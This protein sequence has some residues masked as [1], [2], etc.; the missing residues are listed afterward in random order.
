MRC[1]LIILLFY[2]SNIQAQ[3]Y[4]P[5]QQLNNLTFR[6]IDNTNGL[7]SNNVLSITQDKQGFIWVGSHKGLQRYDGSG[8][9]KYADKSAYSLYTNSRNNNIYFYSE[10]TYNRISLLEPAIT[11]EADNYAP[12]NYFTD[13]HGIRWQVS[14]NVPPGAN[15]NDLPK[16]ISCRVGKA[17][18]NNNHL[19][20]MVAE[21]GG[22]RVWILNNQY[23]L[24]L[25]DYTTHKMYSAGYN[26]LRH[27]LLAVPDK[28]SPASGIIADRRGN[29]W[30]CT[31]SD[32]F[33]RYHMPTGTFSS[34]STQKIHAQSRESQSWVNTVFTDNHG[35]VW[36]ATANAGLLQYNPEKDN[37]NYIL[38]EQKNS[39]SIQYNYEIF[40]LFQDR[41]ENIWVGSDKGISVFNPYRRYFTILRHEEDNRYS[42][43]KSEITG[44]IETKNGDLLIAT[45]GAG[46]SVY[47]SLHRFKRVLRFSYPAYQVNLVWSFVEQ[48]DGTI[49]AGCQHGFLLIINPD[50]WAVQYIRPPQMENATIR[51]MLKDR[52]G[53]V[54]FGLHNGKIAQWNKN[55]DAFYPYNDSAARIRGQTEV[56]NIFEDSAG[57]FWAMT[58]QGLK[59]FDPV[60]RAFMASFYP[61]KK[62]APVK[63]A[64]NCCGIEQFNDSLLLVGIEN[65]GLH[66]FNKRTKHF[67]V[68][69]INEERLPY[70]AYAIKKDK[71]GNVW[72]TTDYDIYKYNTQTQTAVTC[73]PEKG[74][75]SA[76]FVL[77]RF[78]ITGKGQWFSCTYAEVIGFYPGRIS[79]QQTNPVPVTITGLKVFD[80]PVFI[81]SLLYAGKPI[82]LSYRQNFLN[83]EFASLLYAGIHQTKYYYQLSNVDKKWV[84]AG[85]KRFASYTNLGPGK[86]TFSVKAE[87]GS[88]TSKITTMEIEI[89]TPF[90]QT[91]WFIL[92]CTAVFIGMLYVFIR[93]RISSVR[94]AAHMKQKMS[95]TEM[96]AL[97]AQ[98]NPHFIFNCINSIDAMIQSNE[99]Y[100]ATVYLNKFAKLIRNIL[101]SSRHTTIPLGRDLETLQLYIDMEQFRNDNKFVAE[102]KADESLLQE[103]YRVPPLVIQPY[104]ENAILHGLRNRIDNK[105][106]LS[107]VVSKQANHLVYV[108]EDNGVGRQRPEPEA[109]SEEP[110][111]G[112]YRGEGNNKSYGMQMSRDRVKLFNNEEEAAVEITDLKNNGQPAGTKVKV[113]LKIQ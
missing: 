8:F 85:G 97:R 1:S 40:C 17:D 61:G 22:Q 102:I 29:I 45:W 109:G 55:D 105:G 14:M 94:R 46:I 21:P 112:N 107:I 79:E 74:S 87:T 31:W 36:I 75:I 20:F 96:M 99:K 24:R 92:L 54:W 69:V 80:K 12:A 43:P 39:N 70:T 6:H 73:N 113:F 56:M 57:A 28:V 83:I 26:P 15:F 16:A 42:L 51:C 65:K 63:F 103:D 90:W 49:W 35:T 18:S 37:F 52:Q 2:F 78:Y 41:E 38:H 66:F 9:V 13:Q 33:Y 91:A 100:H 81:D 25:L 7:L 11:I 106:K 44:V 60:K 101:D 32:K 48:E 10:T 95:E 93:L 50:T 47:D 89:E 62:S 110:L 58:K 104:V 19:A 59:Q 77:T 86:Y 68:V 23:G 84:D 71:E 72:F 53:N 30:L 111:Q 98:M 88:N 34:Y 67:T 3:P 5:G 108:I 76:P 27:P 4:I 64:Y 82:R